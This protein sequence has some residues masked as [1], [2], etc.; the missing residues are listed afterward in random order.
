MNKL[1]EEILR[2]IPYLRRFA[3]ALTGSQRRGDAFIRLALEGLLADR[4]NV[5]AAKDIKVYL[6]RTFVSIIQHLPQDIS[7]YEAV[8]YD[9]QS[10]PE[11]LESLQ[12]NE[13][14]VLLLISL[15]G[16]T[17]AEV[18][19]IVGLSEGE[20]E[21]LLQCAQ[22]DMLRHAAVGV[23]II[24]DEPVIALDIAGI[25]E[26]MG[27][28]VLATAANKDDAI[29]AAHRLHPDLILADIQLD[30]G[31]SGI[32][33][34]QEILQSIK[35]PAIFVTAYPERLLTGDRP[36]PAYLVTKPF[37]PDTLKV[38]ISQALLSRESR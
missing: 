38:A 25:V 30:D 19:E 31:S 1:S 3:R 9:A 14:M 29:S 18:S 8:G 33:V 34:V 37:R 16:F 26:E 32:T 5:A 17:I 21:Y 6:Y 36:E 35:A 12:P 2:N 22:A 7:T 27:H 15:E 24:E 11:R 4:S 10:L 20:V 13:R 23:L 28:N